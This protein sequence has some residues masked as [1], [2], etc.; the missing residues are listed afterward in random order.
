MKKYKSMDE[1]LTQYGTRNVIHDAFPYLVLVS[2][3]YA[4]AFEK[5]RD[6]KEIAEWLE[7]N[8]QREDWMS[9]F[10]IVSFRHSRDAVPF[11]LKF[12]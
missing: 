6:N 5:A 8:V 12:G 10:D 3:D 2:G 11:R 4:K 9:I 7:E 1:T